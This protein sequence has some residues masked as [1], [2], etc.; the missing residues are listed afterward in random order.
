MGASVP[1]M[2]PDAH[3]RP[4]KRGSQMAA[5]CIAPSVSGASEA[6]QPKHDRAALGIISHTGDFGGFHRLGGSLSPELRVDN[7][8]HRGA[9]INY[10]GLLTEPRFANQSGRNTPI[11]CARARH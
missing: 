4:F 8:A 11:P 9:P 3:P 7:V 5:I 10:A 6:R 1:Q 2:R